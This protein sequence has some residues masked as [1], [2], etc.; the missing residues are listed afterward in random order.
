MPEHSPEHPA[1]PNIHSLD[2]AD[3]SRALSSIAERS[4][5]LINDFVKRQSG[6][7]DP[8]TFDPLNIAGAFLEMTTRLMTDPGKLV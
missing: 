1:S 4:Q 2:P 8:D 6:E 5:R 7:T 3:V